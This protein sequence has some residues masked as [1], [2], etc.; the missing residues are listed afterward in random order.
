MIIRKP[1]GRARSMTTPLRTSAVLRPLCSVFAL[2]AAGAGAQD[3][4]SGLGM[5]YGGD[6]GSLH[7]ATPSLGGGGGGGGGSGG[8]GFYVVPTFSANATLTNNVDLSATNKKSDLVLGVSPGI[9][10]GGQSGRVR[11]FLNYAL[12]G[13]FHARSDQSSSFSN[14]LGASGTV[15]AIDNWLFVDATAS[16]S[17]QFLSPFGAQSSN[18]SLNNDNRTE[19]RS[20]SLAPR[21]Q[22]QI[23]GQVNYVGRAFYSF[24]DSGSSQASDST[25]W[26]A[27]LGFDSTTRWSRL[28][29]GLDFSYREARFSDRRSEFDQ[30][31]VLSLSYAV[32][33]ELRATLRG[34]VENSN[35]TSI[36]DE[37]HT[38]WGAGVHWRP[39]PRTNLMVDYDQRVFGS[40]HLYSLDYR[41]PRTVWAVS[42][43]Q[44]LSTG[45]SN[46][47]RGVST[48]P[49]NLLFT[50][51][52]AIEPDPVKRAQL[53]NA[54]L[55]ANG[56]DPNASLN[57]GYL[58]NQVTLERRNEASMA[59][60]GQRDT[61]VATV[62]QT[63]SQNLQPSLLNPADPFSG[64]NVIRWRGASLTWSHRLTPR[65]TLSV[66]GLGQN[67]SESIGNQDTTLWSGMAMWSNQVAERV[68]VSLSARYQTQSGSTS[69]DEAALLATLNMSF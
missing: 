61:M 29:W 48:S 20:V 31:N 52:A 1:V 18:S 40:S 5:G 12:T 27:L 4:G 19:V 69:F 58:P 35:L 57:A 49:F 67:S 30:L 66:S 23:A 43:R 54:F 10:L 39:S 68:G 55:R 41:T 50:Q 17:Q 6:G 24:T 8:R 13:N 45:Q 53:V 22:G 60:L 44:G 28:S 38:G 26:G 65:S 62:Y 25:V 46:S 64:G 42:S 36:D 32:T 16:V 3:M 9:Q 47:G 11:G 37:T 63:E 14:S 51:F 2:A 15:E 56:I 34:N 7:S 33:P 21:V 59:W